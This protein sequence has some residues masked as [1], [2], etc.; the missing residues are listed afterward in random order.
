MSRHLG[1]ADCLFG[2]SADG[3]LVEDAIGS[4]RLDQPF[5]RQERRGERRDPQPSGCDAFE[6]PGIGADRERNERRDDEEES[7]RQPGRPS[8]RSPDVAS[9]ERSDQAPSSS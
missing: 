3:E 7:D 1:R 6:Q 8:D 9:D 5:D 4:I 2:S